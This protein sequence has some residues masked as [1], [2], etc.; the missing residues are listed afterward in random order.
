[1][2]ML[3]FYPPGKYVIRDR[4]HDRSLL[5]LLVD[6]SAVQRTRYYGIPGDTISE[7]DAATWHAEA[8]G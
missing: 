4:Q 5:E 7:S 8:H 6:A 3:K 1:M 2:M